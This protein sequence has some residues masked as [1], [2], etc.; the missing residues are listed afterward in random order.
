MSGRRSLIAAVLVYV[1]LDLSLPSMP[2]AFV[3]E[4]SDSVEGTYA[5]HSRD[6]TVVAAVPA[7]PVDALTVTV[8]PPPIRLGVA[9]AGFVPRDRDRAFPRGVLEPAAPVDDH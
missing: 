5:S 9:P 6:A 3:F 1:T 2:G 7:P 8:P 4:P